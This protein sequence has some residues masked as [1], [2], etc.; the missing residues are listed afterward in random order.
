MMLDK[1]INMFN[2]VNSNIKK[3][4][5]DGFIF[6]FMLAIVSGILLYTYD[7]FYSSI[8]LYYIGFYLFKNSLLFAC[9]FFVFGIGFDKIK[10][11]LEE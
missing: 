1:V 2:S 4:M 3:I 10:K 7:T 6:C 9:A 11:D 5:K 8:M